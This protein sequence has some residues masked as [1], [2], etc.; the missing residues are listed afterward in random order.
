MD[1][2]TN[3]L[4]FLLETYFNNTVSVSKLI[5][6]ITIIILQIPIKSIFYN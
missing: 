5:D 4:K 3:L 2:L 1:N 6:C